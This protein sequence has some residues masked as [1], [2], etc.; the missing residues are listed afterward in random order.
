MWLEKNE[1]SPAVARRLQ[2]RVDLGRVV[3]VVVVDLDAARLAAT[4]EAPPC[5]REFPEHR[6]GFRARHARALERGQR[7]RCV[8]AVVLAGDGERA[9]VRREVVAAH[10]CRHVHE[11]A[12]EEQ[13][14]LGPRPERRVM[15]EVDVRHDGDAGSERGDRAVGFVS[16]HDQPACTGAG[17]AAELRNVAADQPGGLAA[18]SLEAEGDH[19]GGRR[20]PVGAC[21]DDR[22]TQGDELRQQLGSGPAGDAV[23]E[24]ARHVRFPAFGR[25]RR[26]FRDVDGDAVE[27]L[28]VGRARAI[29]P[30]Y[31]GSPR[32]REQRVSAHAGPADPGEPPAA[33]LKGRG[34]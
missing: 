8:A 11:P 5:A 13:L 22:V 29:P 21:D 34:Q 19:A 12:L 14:H 4:L 24:R 7:G 25:R 15:V 6:L 10:D 26:I 3:R 1:E 33:A 17:I 16:L 20:L 30:T 32:L 18:E 28:E 23:G 2:R 31:L 27:A 9:F